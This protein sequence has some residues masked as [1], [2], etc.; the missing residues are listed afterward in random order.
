[1]ENLLWFPNFYVN[2][3]VTYESVPSKLPSPQ[4]AADHGID[5]EDYGCNLIACIIIHPGANENGYWTNDDVANHLRHTIKL[6]NTLPPQE[7]YQAL[8][9]FDNSSNHQCYAPDALNIPLKCKRWRCSHEKKMHDESNKLPWHLKMANKQGCEGFL[10][11]G[12]LI[13]MGCERAK[14]SPF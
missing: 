9:C 11:K 2:A 7:D 5:P 8:F 3:T 12:I 4:Q 14:W 6:F 1:M 10:T 13:Q